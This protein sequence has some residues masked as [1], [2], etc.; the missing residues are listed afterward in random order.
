MLK[1]LQAGLQQYM[2]REHPDIQAGFRKSRGTRG[3]I[4]NISRIIEK[5]KKR[6]PEKTSTSVSLIVLK[7]LILWITTN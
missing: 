7:P 6:V 2:N 3:Q 4:A 1:I 5:K